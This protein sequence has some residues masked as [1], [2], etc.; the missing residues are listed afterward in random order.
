[1]II[2]IHHTA[3]SYKKN[4]DQFKATDNYHKSLNYPISS[5]GFY[6]GYNYEIA[7]NG[8]VSQARA[9]GEITAAVPQDGMN[10][11]KAIHICLDGNFDEEKPGEFQIYVLRDL[12]K[13][14]IKEY[15]IDDIR[16]HRDYNSSKSCP[17]KNI[18]IDWIK[19]MVGFTPIKEEAQK[20]DI[21]KQIKKHLEEITKLLDLCPQ[22]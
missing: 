16:G 3:V 22:K 17:G 5:L 8:K 13:K 21:K 2:C 1:M 4:K 18:D 10:T 15:K 9:V 19:E 20:Q 7:L 12:L 11:G 6:V 14:L